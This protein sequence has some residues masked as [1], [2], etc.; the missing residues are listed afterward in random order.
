MLIQ[1]DLFG[2][3]LRKKLKF[4]SQNV[5]SKELQYTKE[6]LDWC[7]FLYYFLNCDAIDLAVVT[8]VA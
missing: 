7:S 3:A 6:H 2:A 4:Y 5:N 8:L 1:R